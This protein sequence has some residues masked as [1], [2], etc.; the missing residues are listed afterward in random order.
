ML[1]FHTSG[2][3]PSKSCPVLSLRLHGNPD[4]LSFGRA[5]VNSDKRNVFRF[6]TYNRLSSDAGKG[7]ADYILEAF[8]SV[9]SGRAE[10][11]TSDMFGA[12]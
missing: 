12:H 8:A 7:S 10:P 3:H 4:N 2:D 9:D 11:L 1:T 5:F 6:E